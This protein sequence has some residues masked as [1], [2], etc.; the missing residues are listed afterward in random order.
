MP[1]G[2]IIIDGV[3]CLGFV[4]IFARRSLG[5]TLGT[6][7]LGRQQEKNSG[8]YQEHDPRRDQPKSKFTMV[9]ILP[10]A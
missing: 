2:A 10:P 6:N 7:R 5:T 4:A 1:R 3:L 8:R 9:H